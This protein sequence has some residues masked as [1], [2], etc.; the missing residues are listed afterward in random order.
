MTSTP[1]GSPE[2]GIVLPNSGVAAG[3]VTAETLVSLAA[4]ADATDV[5]DYVWV[6]DSLISVPRLES[7]VLLSAC[8]VRTRRVRLG[9]ACQ[10]S[11][12]LREPVLATLQWASLDVLSEGR[13]TLVACTGPGRGDAAARELSVF[14]LNHS[15][16]VQRMEACVELIRQA[17]TE[18]V[19]SKLVG[20]HPELVPIS[21]AFVQRPF[22]VWM[23]ANPSPTAVCA[24]VKR[25]LERVARLGDGWMTF[26]VPPAVLS[27]RV[28]LLS[29]MLPAGGKRLDGEFPI[30]VYVDVNVSEDERQAMDDA[31]ATCRLEGRRNATAESLNQTAA[32]GSVSRCV[33]FLVPLFEAGATSLALRPVSH[34]PVRQMEVLTAELVPSLKATLGGRTG[35]TPSGR[36]DDGE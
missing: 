19:L 32:I 26:A 30:C 2:V 13:M 7:V 25:R 31:V 18:G 4:L 34:D 11:L 36:A 21:P 20:D 5:W 1:S 33:E 29:L 9:A 16:R 15:Q 23:T 14:G 10:A 17:S 3:Y 6:G 22:P 35:R 28:Q 12:G 24:E 8:A 27:E